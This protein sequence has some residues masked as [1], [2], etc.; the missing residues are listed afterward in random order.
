MI[1]IFQLIFYILRKMKIHYNYQYPNFSNI[2]A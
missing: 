1:K 2:F